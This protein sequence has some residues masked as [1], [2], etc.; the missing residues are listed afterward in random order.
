MPWMAMM[1]NMQQSGTAMGGALGGIIGDS[2]AR[3]SQDAANNAILQ[4]QAILAQVQIPSPEA[5]QVVLEHLQQ[6]GQLTPELQIALTQQ[7]SEL[8]NFVPNQ[9]QQDAQKAALQS[10][11]QTGRAGLNASDRAELQQIRNQTAQQVKGQEQAILQNMAQR[12]M[13]G[14]GEELAARLMAGQQGAELANT[15]GNQLAA[16][17]QQR[18]LQAL[19]QSGQLAGQMTQADFSRAQQIA[20]AQ[21]AINRFN[22]GNSQQVQAANVLA[23]NQAQEANLKEKQRIADT[24]VDLQNKQQMYNKQV[25]VDDFERRF[26]KATGQSSNLVSAIAPMFNQEAQAT[27]NKFAGLG[28]ALGGGAGAAGSAFSKSKGSSEDEEGAGSA[29]SMAGSFGGS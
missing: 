22:T 8:G 10:M 18:S 21:D 17:A 11:I 6:Q 16:Q 1:G 20:Q 4:S 26:R 29:A 27:R 23:K 2:A 13:G 7:A 25:L 9:D 19:A 5:L 24:N 28:A 14:S 15:Q 3:G 12:G